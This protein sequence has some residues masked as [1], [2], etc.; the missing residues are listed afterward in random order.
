MSK[1]TTLGSTLNASMPATFGNT[2]INGDLDVNG[3]LRVSTIVSSSILYDSGSTIFGNTLDDTHEFTGSIYITGSIENPSSITFSNTSVPTTLEN[4]TLAANTTDKTLDLRMGVNA[5]LQLG[6]ELYYPPIVNKSGGNLPNGCLVMFNPADPTQGNRIA[7]VKCISDGTYPADFIVG[8]LTEDIAVNQEGFATWFGYVR[9]VN[10]TELE[11]AGLKDPAETWTEGQ[12]LY[13]HPTRAGGLTNVQPTAPNL[14]SS[15][16][17]ITSINGVNITF[18]VR[19]HLRGTIKGLHDTIDTS[20]NSSYGDLLIKSGSVWTN[21]KTLVGDYTISGSLFISGATEFGGNLVPKSAQGAT[22]GTEERPFS[23]IFLSSGSINIASDIPGDP[24]TSLSNEGGNILVSAG[25]MR[26]VGDA[27]FIAQTGSFQ[28]ISGSMTQ[29]GDYTQLGTHVLT[30][31]Q[32]ITGSLN[33]TGSTFQVGNNNLIGNTVLSGNMNISGSTKLTGSLDVMGNIDVASGSGFFYEGNKLFNRGQF[34]H[35][36]TLSGSANTAYPFQ[37]NTTDTTVT[38]GAVYV[39]NTSRVYV[40][41]TGIYNIQFSSQLRAV[42]N[43]PIEFS[44]WF[45]M[46]GSNIMNSNTDYS[47][48]KVGGGGNMVAALNYLMPLSSGSYFEIYYSK[49][50]TDGQIEAKGVQTTPIRPGTPSIILTVTQI[51]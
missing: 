50:R 37:Y 10:R 24:N 36:A 45:A 17:A 25:G 38:N 40:K 3:N 43:D 29:I 23:D 21:S 14:K 27:S 22:L 12:I 16:C 33:V 5:T 39:D 20:T 46:T 7:V 28:F 1:R 18:L 9:D 26:L 44:I 30:G 2:T 11:N 34:Y 15:I 51:A 19:P 31:N 47:I 42:T 48:A 41:H 13:P 6:Q 35:T 8:V 49:T 4:Y 32:T